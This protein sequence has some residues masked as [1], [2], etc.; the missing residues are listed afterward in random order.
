MT[1]NAVVIIPIVF[2]QHSSQLHYSSFFRRPK[3]PHSQR[4][5]L[6][7]SQCHRGHDW[8]QTR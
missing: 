5:G 3:V 7:S 4:K 6:H 1:S 8:S 2:F